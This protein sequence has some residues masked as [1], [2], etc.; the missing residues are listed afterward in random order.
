MSCSTDACARVAEVVGA[1]EVRE[2]PKSLV[3]ALQNIQQFFR[4][5]V[6]RLDA[7]HLKVCRCQFR[8]ERL[9]F[10]ALRSILT[11]IRQ[12]GEMVAQ[13]LHLEG[14][15]AGIVGLCEKEFQ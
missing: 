2:L 10:L 1:E 13:R 9:E 6:A 12:P 7:E 15:R 5:T 3:E 11:G 8:C 14:Q 4:F